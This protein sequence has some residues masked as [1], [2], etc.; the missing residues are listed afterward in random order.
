METE[1]HISSLSWMGGRQ[2]LTSPRPLFFFC[3]AC[4]ILVPQPEME[5]APL[6][7]KVQSPWTTREF[8]PPLSSNRIHPSP[9]PL[10]GGHCCSDPPWVLPTPAVPGRPRPRTAVTALGATTYPDPSRVVSVSTCAPLVQ[11][12]C[13]PPGLLTPKP[14]K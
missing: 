4:G 1:N 6:A 5:P 2:L 8:P 7:V 9:G 10:R 11:A 3:M 14:G 13:R 12:Y